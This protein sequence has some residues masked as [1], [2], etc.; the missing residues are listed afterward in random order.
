MVILHISIYNHTICIKRVIST[1]HS[2]YN[3]TGQNSNNLQIF[4]CNENGKT[5]TISKITVF[6][7]TYYSVKTNHLI[8]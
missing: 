1:L 7:L 6:F 2:R 4:N 8:P 5:L 3:F